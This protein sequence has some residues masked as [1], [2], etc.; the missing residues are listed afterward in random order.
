MFSKKL[1]VAFGAIVV[2]S[3]VL[4]GCVTPTPETIVETVVVKETVEVETIVEKTVE[5]IKEVTPEPTPEPEAGPK[6]PCGLPGTGTRDIMVP[7]RQYVGISPH[8]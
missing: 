4:S 3:L 5:V 7:W 8:L 1:M 2:L 6:N